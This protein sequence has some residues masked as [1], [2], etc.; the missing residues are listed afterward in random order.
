MARRGYR[1]CPTRNQSLGTESGVSVSD[2]TGEIQ[3]LAEA[4]AAEH[5]QVTYA[6]LRE[7]FFP[8]EDGKIVMSVISPRCFEAAALRTLMIMYP[9][10]YSRRLEPHRHYVVLNRDHS[11][12][13]EVLHT[14][15]TPALATKIIETSYGEVA[16]AKHNSY[17]A[18]TEHFSAVVRTNFPG[19][20]R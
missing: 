6:E 11:N 12:M 2:F 20:L 19:P 5:P 17:Q 10:E 13:D 8:D 16:L 1:C 7:R 9:G 14:L 4:Y 3:R 15:R 18:L